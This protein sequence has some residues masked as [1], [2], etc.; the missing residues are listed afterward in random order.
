M[1]LAGQVHAN[2]EWKRAGLLAADWSLRQACCSN[3]NYNA[4]SISLLAHAFRI[5]GEKKYLEGA[6]QKFRV[7]VAPGQ[8][9]NGRWIDSHN[10]RTVYHVILLR[11]LGDLA[12]V[13]PANLKTER[14]ELDQVARPAIEALLNEFDAMGITVEALPE[15][16]TL[17]SLYPSD[18]RLQETVKDMAAVIVGKCTDG[19]HVK[20]GAQPNQ[21]AAVA[22]ACSVFT[23]AAIPDK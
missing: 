20:M 2:D 16:L 10:A 23:K 8:S 12:S 19:R 5:S 4:F 15:L 17:A 6:L 14:A 3:F 9:P 21:L 18:V 11:A 7:G 22:P 1:L 13:L